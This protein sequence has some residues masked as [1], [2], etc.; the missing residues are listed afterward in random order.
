M[1]A[2]TSY[3]E[4]ILKK[5]KL[6]D[7]IENVDKMISLLTISI[8][9]FQKMIKEIRESIS[10][11]IFACRSKVIEFFLTNRL[12][13]PNT[14]LTP[15]L[16]ITML[17][18]ELTLIVKQ[19]EKFNEIKQNK[20][21]ELLKITAKLEPYKNTLLPYQEKVKEIEDN[22]VTLTINFATY[23][24]VIHDWCAGKNNQLEYITMA[25]KKSITQLTTAQ[26]H[27]K[28]NLSNELK[29][30][31]ENDLNNMKDLMIKNHA[32]ATACIKVEYEQ[33]QKDFMQS[34]DLHQKE[35]LKLHDDL[36]T[37]KNDLS[38]KIQEVSKQLE[39]H[40]IYQF[41]QTESINETVTDEFATFR[42]DLLEKAPEN[43]F[44]PSAPI[45]FFDTP[46]QNLISTPTQAIA[47]EDENTSRNA[48]RQKIN[49]N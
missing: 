42:N 28:N 43:L 3:E 47:A 44:S 16:A 36:N 15:A 49:N 21:T 6:T 33:Q 35:L 27:A 2:R 11:R 10:C 25:F 20:L 40:E 46:S 4:C 1:Q 26:E 14:E 22:I 41:L 37:A 24:S 34:K 5:D 39:A 7:E 19:V 31:I 30:K 8:N 13:P 32:Q 45:T 18:K 48:K 17:N 12:T 9:A 29:S 23:Q 38:V